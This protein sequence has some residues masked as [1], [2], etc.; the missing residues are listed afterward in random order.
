[1]IDSWR[2]LSRTDPLQPAAVAARH[3][4]SAAMARR[5]LGR[6]DEGLA[7]LRGVAGHE[8]LLIIGPAEL[9]PW[10]DGAVYLG[11][12]PRAPSLL[13]PTHTEPALCA[14]LIERALLAAF[15]AHLPPIALLP[16]ER[17]ILSANAA[18]PIS[19]TVLLDWLAGTLWVRP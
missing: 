3:A 5:L 10:V 2:W 1:M 6:D 14:A 13:L 15:P 7:A 4:A 17:T 16:S 12:D 18:R 19:R 9:L 8:T 11:R